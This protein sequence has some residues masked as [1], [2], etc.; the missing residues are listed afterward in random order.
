L[1]NNKAKKIGCSKFFSRTFSKALT[2]EVKRKR[3]V[4]GKIS[5]SESTLNNSR[6]A[7]KE[8]ET[9]IKVAKGFSHMAA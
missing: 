3:V 5:S 9:R 6:L 1:N 4:R 8:Q 2:V 7:A